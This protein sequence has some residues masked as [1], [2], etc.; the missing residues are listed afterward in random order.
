MSRFSFYQARAA[1]EAIGLPGLTPKNPGPRGQHKLR[2]EVVAFLESKLT[3]DLS[4]HYRDLQAGVQ[5]R[6]G[7]SLIRPRGVPKDPRTLIIRQG[8]KWLLTT[9]ASIDSVSLG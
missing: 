5:A 4:L 8:S 7:L 1:F 6:F 3:K 2:P 9:I